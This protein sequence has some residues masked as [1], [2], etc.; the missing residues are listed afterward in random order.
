MG[1][2]KIEIK[3]I[4]NSTNR[5]V[6]FSKRRNGLLKKAYELSVLCDAEVALI[7]F[8][9][10]GK[11]Y[12]FANKSVKRTIE[13]Y[14]KTCAKDM[15]WEPT[16]DSILECCQN[17]AGKLRQEISMLTKTNRNLTGDNLSSL[18][19]MELNSLEARLERAINSVRSK[20]NEM[21]LQEMK[22]IQERE[23][24]LL[25]QNQ[26][27]RSK[28]AEYQIGK[29]T[30]TLHFYKEAPHFD[31]QDLLQGNLVDEI[32]EHPQPDLT[33]SQFNLLREEQR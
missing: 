1:R 17:E 13:R 24:L 3:R 21:L 31:T 23:Q 4:E 7:I 2:G 15:R 30:N 10:R 20:R 32:Q 19:M 5:Q 33:I 12:E 29:G 25:A 16:T 11:L 27:L 9:S 8:S 22:A 6:T 26:Y 14:K 18:S 28:I